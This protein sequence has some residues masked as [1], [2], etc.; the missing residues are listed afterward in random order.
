M[1]RQI[2]AFL[3]LTVLAGALCLPPGQASASGRE[4]HEQ[5]RQALEAGQI[6]PL[7][8]ILERVG[9][10]YPGQVLEVE[11]EREQGRWL[12]EIKLLLPDGR[13]LKAEVD[14]RSGE[15]LGTKRRQSRSGAAGER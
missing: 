2:A 6:Q 8:R 9:R 13:L 15:V 1:N 5:A 4:D 10:L 7:S 3:R 12:Y 11:L 14:A